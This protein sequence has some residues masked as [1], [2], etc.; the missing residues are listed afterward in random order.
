MK[1]YAVDATGGVVATVT[2]SNAWVELGYV[3]AEVNVVYEFAPFD[4]TV[5][6]GAYRNCPLVAQ[7]R[8]NS[9][10]V[11]VE[12]P[13]VNSTVPAPAVPT[14]EIVGEV[15]APAPAAAAGLAPVQVPLTNVPV[16]ALAT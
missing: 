14:S 4:V 12:V 5:Q 2:V 11:V 15:P 10:P 8:V 3:V 9:V 13:D 7:V 16:A 6:V 1:E